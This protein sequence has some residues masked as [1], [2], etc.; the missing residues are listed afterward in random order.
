MFNLAETEVCSISINYFNMML[1]NN[2]WWSMGWG[3][4]GWRAG[5]EA[6]DRV[7]MTAPVKKFGRARLSTVFVKRNMADFHEPVSGKRLHREPSH[8]VRI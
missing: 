5:S 7:S 4:G 6:W 1:Y 8:L 3:G 2:M